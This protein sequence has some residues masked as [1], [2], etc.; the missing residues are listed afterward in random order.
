MSFDGFK[1]IIFG[2]GFDGSTSQLFATD[3]DKKPKKRP[4]KPTYELINGIWHVKADGKRY[5][6]ETF[7][8]LVCGLSDMEFLGLVPEGTT[9][10]LRK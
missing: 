4:K 7:E 5:R 3:I 1:T 2:K 6:F 8:K 10:D 9:E